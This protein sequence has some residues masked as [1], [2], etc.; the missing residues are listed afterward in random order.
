MRKVILL[1]RGNLALAI[2]HDDL[3]GNIDQSFFWLVSFYRPHFRA[4]NGCLNSHPT[5]TFSQR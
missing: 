3:T 1:R 5:S 2:E 4:K